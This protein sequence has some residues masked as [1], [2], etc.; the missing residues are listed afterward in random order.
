MKTKAIETTPVRSNAHDALEVFLGEWRAEGLS[1]GG[2]DQSGPDPKANGERWESTHTTRWH[3]G[4]FFVIE[5]ERALIDGKT[6]DTHS[7][8]GLEPGSK[9][10]FARTFEDHG[11]YRHYSMSVDGRTWLLTGEFER[12]RTVFDASG[13]TQTITWEWLRNGKWLPLCDRVAT[14]VDRL[15]IR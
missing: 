5:D 9:G 15:G 10:Y 6:F 12:A 3:T 11:F 7:V 8:M 14:R 1:F 2:T 13:N 4:E